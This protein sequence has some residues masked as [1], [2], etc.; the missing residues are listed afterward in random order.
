M[1][2]QRRIPLSST[3]MRAEAPASPRWIPLP[4]GDFEM[5]LSLPGE[6]SLA[7]AT[8]ANPVL[9]LFAFD[10]ASAKPWRACSISMRPDCAI[11]V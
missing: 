2:V 10:A 7:A 11:S 3:Q 9:A 1:E 8:P 5:A 4:F 6:R